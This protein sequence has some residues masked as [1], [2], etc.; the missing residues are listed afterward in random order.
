[1]DFPS[2][3]LLTKVGIEPLTICVAWFGWQLVKINKE[4]K[5]TLASH[6]KRIDKVE[7]EQERI[8]DKN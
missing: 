6:D 8:V 2:I 4:I 3:A 1:M 5:S 7:W